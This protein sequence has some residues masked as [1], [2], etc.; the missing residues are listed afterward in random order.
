MANKIKESIKNNPLQAFAL[1][2]TIFITLAN[3]V[4]GYFLLTIS[5]HLAPLDKSISVLTTEIEANTNTDTR[6]H[7]LF[8]TKDSFLSLEKTVDHINQ[9]V[10]D[11]Y[12]IL[13]GK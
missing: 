4:V 11:I 9:R 8:V 12:K 7:A 6:E 2:F 13:G 1:G 10:D 3:V 5:S